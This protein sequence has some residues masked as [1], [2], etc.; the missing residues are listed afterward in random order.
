MASTL[1]GTRTGT[2]AGNYVIQVSYKYPKLFQNTAL[3]TLSMSQMNAPA[4][5]GPGLEREQESTTLYKYPKLF[6]NTCTE[7]KT[8]STSQM[9]A[10]ALWEP[11][12]EWF[13]QLVT[14]N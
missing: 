3:K 9:N 2:R 14:Q 1:W 8:L 6:L 5:W 12:L 7:L 13:A 4:L 11:G 10:P